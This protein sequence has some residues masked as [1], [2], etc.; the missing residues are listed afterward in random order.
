MFIV[1]LLYI[2]LKRKRDSLDIYALI[3]F[4]GLYIFWTSDA[5]LADFFFRNTITIV[6]VVSIYIAGFLMECMRRLRID[7]QFLK[8]ICLVV[9]YLSLGSTVF[10]MPGETVN[11][12]SYVYHK[13]AQLIESSSFKVYHFPF[14]KL[15]KYI[16]ANVSPDAKILYPNRYAPLPFYNFKY[17]LNTQWTQGLS[18]DID[19]IALFNEYIR[20]SDF[21]YVVLDN[22]KYL[23]RFHSE[24]KYKSLD[25]MSEF[26]FGK[27]KLSIYKVKRR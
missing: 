14:R 7:K 5:W 22:S 12:A 21:D 11:F 10:P 27:S 2:L 3:L 16:E 26:T 15:F 8:V 23:V 6:P 13:K 9:L 25:L 4:A 1:S 18:K 20:S 17:K 24:V 19:N